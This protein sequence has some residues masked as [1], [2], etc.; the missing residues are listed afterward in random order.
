MKK[1]FL[2]CS[3]FFYWH[4]RKRFYPEGLSPNKWLEFYSK[5]FNSVEI[6]SSFYNF[7]KTSSLKQWFK[8]TPEE[9]VF[10]VKANKL[11]THI[12]RFHHTK[13]LLNSFYSILENGLNEKLGCVLFQLPPSMHFNSKLL[14]KICLQLDSNFNNVLEFRHKSWF[15]SMKTFSILE[16]HSIGFC[17]VSSPKMPEIIKTTSKT[18]YIRFHG[19]Q[20]LYASNYSVKELMEWVKKIKK[21]RVKELFAYFNNDF[22][23]FAPKNCLQLKKLLNQLK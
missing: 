19:K 22:N 9:F 16:N 13:R 8:K 5:K 15:E 21:L 3:G 18:A 7:P 1:F 11:I 12:K 17:I 14:E 10:S 6:N 20:S 23:A 2:G 4:W